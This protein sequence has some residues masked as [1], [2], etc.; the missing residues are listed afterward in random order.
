ML[1]AMASGWINREYQAVADRFAD[2]VF[3]SDSLHYAFFN[4]GDLLRF[5]EDE[6]LP[7]N[8]VFHQAVF[9]EEVQ[10][11][12]AEYTYEGTYRY[13]GTGWIKLENDKIASWREYQH[14]SDLGRKEF[15]KQKAK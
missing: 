7:E 13:H 10:L 4:K 12:A 3:Y 8:C 5:F 1:D 11:G 14:I 6:D 15:W 2:D 9:D